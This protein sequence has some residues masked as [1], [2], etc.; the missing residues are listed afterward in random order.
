MNATIVKIGIIALAI[1]VAAGAKY[2]LHLPDNNP[3]EKMATGFIDKELSEDDPED[4]DEFV[5]VDLNQ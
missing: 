5:E 4:S 2:V 3:I 1:L